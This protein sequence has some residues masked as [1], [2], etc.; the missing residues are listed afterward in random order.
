MDI[1]EI[2]PRHELGRKI[3]QAREARG[4]SQAALAGILGVSQVT[5][6][7]WEAG[8]RVMKARQVSEVARALS[9]P[10]EELTELVVAALHTRLSSRGADISMPRLQLPPEDQPSASDLTSVG[11]APDARCPREAEGGRARQARWPGHAARPPAGERA[12]DGQLAYWGEIGK[13]RVLGTAEAGR[14]MGWT[15]QQGVLLGE[16]LG[17]WRGFIGIE[18]H[19]ESMNGG[20]K[21]IAGGDVVIVDPRDCDPQRLLGCCVVVRTEDGEMVKEL[22]LE[23]GRYYLR[24][25]NRQYPIIEVP[26]GAELMGRVVAVV[27]KL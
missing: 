7:H 14:A 25:W 4:L 3:I 11:V 1:P 20:D 13:I 27:R 19:G 5:I 15:G 10:E 12:P 9:V 2:D 16:R 6:S 17:D 23:R 21:P 22:G 18:V 26:E 24:S 8:R